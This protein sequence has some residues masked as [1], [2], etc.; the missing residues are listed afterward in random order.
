MC[1]SVPQTPRLLL[2]QSLRGW[3]SIEG[4]QSEDSVPGIQQN[5][6][7]KSVT[8]WKRKQA[9]YQFRK[10]SHCLLSHPNIWSS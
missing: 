4:A 2:I 7:L 10:R 1:L 5:Y 8:H 3:R 6:E 9:E